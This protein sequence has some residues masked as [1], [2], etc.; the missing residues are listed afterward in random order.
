MLGIDPRAARA[1]WTVFLIGLLL[2]VV[3]FTRSVLLIFV[4]AI[5][6]AYLLAPIVNLVDRWLTWPRSRTLSLAL[7]YVALIVV[8]IGAGTLIGRQ[9]AEEASAL[10]ASFPKLVAG[11]DEPLDQPALEWLEPVR[12]YALEQI[13]E[14][15]QTFGASVMPLVQ[16]ATAHVLSVLN[17][18]LIVVMVPILG[19]FFLKDGPYLRNQV[20]GLIDAEKRAVWEDIAADVHALLGQFIRALTI[21][22]AATL[23]SYG[24]FF[25]IIGMPYGAL[26]ATVAGVLEFIPFFGPLTAAA[27]IVLVALFSKFGHVLLI[28]AF[29]GGYRIF[30]DYVLTPHL[31]GA[32]VALHPLLI[33]FGAL[34]GEELAGI[35]GMFLSVPVLATL[36]VLYVRFQKTRVYTTSREPH[37]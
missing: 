27:I 4:I 8:L 36:R 24:V 6:F 28:L 21:L 35:P 26:L 1:A 2:V 10:A 12:R 5:L 37:L 33:I 30:Q 14:K 22:A 25:F 20:L 17:S 34:A 23:V 32:G 13:R 19:F 7:V 16:R 11:L 15:A 29:L 9:V 3:W 31:M 18:V